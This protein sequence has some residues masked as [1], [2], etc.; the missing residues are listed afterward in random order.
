MQ[1]PEHRD[2]LE[3][4]ICFHIKNGSE[5]TGHV[6]HNGEAMYR[7]RSGDSYPIR[8]LDEVFFSQRVVEELN[9]KLLH[10]YMRRIGL[11]K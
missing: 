7:V 1:Q 9:P 2:E 11:P 10:S 6:P 3:A 4:L 5:I 8:E